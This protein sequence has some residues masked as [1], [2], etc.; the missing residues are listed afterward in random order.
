[1]D[2][3][4]STIASTFY[5]FPI[6]IFV[7]DYHDFHLETWLCLLLLLFILWANYDACINGHKR[8]HT[9]DYRRDDH[10]ACSGHLL[11]YAMRVGEYIIMKWI[12]CHDDKQISTGQPNI[13]IHIFVRIWH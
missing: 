5:Y 11:H 3:Q 2:A 7:A 4:S 10:G 9:D 12:V 13:H 1:M 6:F 8:R